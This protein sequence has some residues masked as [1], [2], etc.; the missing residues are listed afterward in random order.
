VTIQVY[1]AFGVLAG[2]TDDVGGAVTGAGYT[3]LSGFYGK[4][5]S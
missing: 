1:G 2:A 3:D 5:R 4:G